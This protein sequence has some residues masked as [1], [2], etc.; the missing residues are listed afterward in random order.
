MTTHEHTNTLAHVHDEMEHAQGHHHVNYL[1]VFIALC[2]CTLLSIAFDIIHMPKA[3]T[4]ALVLA[5]AVAKASF[6]LTYFMHLKFEGGWKYIILAP[7]AILAVGLMIALAP[8]IGL[9]YYTPDVPQL[10]ALE[11]QGDHPH[12]HDTGKAVS[13]GAKAH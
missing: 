13:D 11:E 4:V 3:V 12:D 2:I 8:D 5:V 9:H 10:R 7:T 1:S 6:V